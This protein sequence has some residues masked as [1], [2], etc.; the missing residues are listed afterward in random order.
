MKAVTFKLDAT[1]P[2]VIRLRLPHRH[3]RPANVRTSSKISHFSPDACL[4]AGGPPST[5]FARSPS[6]LRVTEEELDPACN[7]IQTSQSAGATC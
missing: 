3:H 5:S 4:F 2:L 1:L 7:P 6:R